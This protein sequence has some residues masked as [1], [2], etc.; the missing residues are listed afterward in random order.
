MSDNKEVEAVE[1]Y[2][3]LMMELKVSITELVGKID[4][5]TD[6]KDT[7]KETKKTAD[8]A[9]NRSLEN[10]K[11]IATL[12]TKV[13]TKANKDE[14]VKKAEKSD[15]DAINKKLEDGSNEKRDWKRNLPAWVAVAISVVGILFKYI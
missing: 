14:L 10:E 5:L 11:D 9:D 4:N 8:A 13:S 2:Y 6:M 1:K 3:T 7:L 15:V 12:Q